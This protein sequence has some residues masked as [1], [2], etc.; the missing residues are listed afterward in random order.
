MALQSVKHN[1]RGVTSRAA[2]SIPSF[3]DILRPMW[4][5]W[6]FHERDGS[7]ITPRYLY[8]LY[9]RSSI[10]QG[11]YFLYRFRRWLST[12]VWTHE[13]SIREE[14]HHCQIGKTWW[15]RRGNLIIPENKPLA[16]YKTHLHTT[17]NSWHYSC[18]CS[19][20]C[21]SIV[22]FVVYS[23]T[24]DAFTKLFTCTKVTMLWSDRIC[25]PTRSGKVRHLSH[26]PS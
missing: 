23:L 24:I 20:C 8:L 25:G 11:I 4:S 21:R 26:Q 15:T 10:L 16:H 18:T 2:R 6:L 14:L 22:F 3:A 19:L 7:C 5:L 17:S 12:R 13:E 1:S 9:R